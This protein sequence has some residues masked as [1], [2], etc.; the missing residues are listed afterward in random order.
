MRDPENNLIENRNFENSEKYKTNKSDVNHS[1]QLD[2][3][4]MHSDTVYNTK[5]RDG[6]AKKIISI[7]DDYYSG[8]L[9]NLSLLD[10]GCSAGFISNMLSKHFRKVI[11]I[12]I[13]H[14]AVD[15]AI[16]NN[17]AKNLQFAIRDGMNLN[18]LDNTFDVV[19]CNHIYEHVPNSK[20]LIDEIYRVLKPGGICYF[21]AGNRLKIMEDHYKLPFLSIIPK[22][23]AHLYLRVLRLDEY[24]YE[25]HLTYWELKELVKNFTIIDYTTKVIRNPN[26]YYAIDMLRQ[27]CLKQRLALFISKIAYW[28][29]PTY[30]WLLH[31]KDKK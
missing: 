9:N 12:D 5:M 18:F 23:L 8:K 10:I 28:L 2:Y 26:K 11:A 24:Y 14:K 15:Y 4:K 25:K 30:I 13:D 1:Y 31:K 3:S 29:C 21:A 20:K 17:S 7:F 27:G 6:K 16:K 22:P 19:V